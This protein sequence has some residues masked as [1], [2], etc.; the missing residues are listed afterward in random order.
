[1]KKTITQIA[2]RRGTFGDYTIEAY[3]YQ[4]S[5]DDILG[6]QSWS[7]TSSNAK[8]NTIHRFR[9]VEGAFVDTL[10]PNNE[11][12]VTIADM[13]LDESKQIMAAITEWEIVE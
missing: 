3:K 11:G 13:D 4:A 9:L 2:A 10:P 8:N 6:D 12:F 1:M 7:V 5:T